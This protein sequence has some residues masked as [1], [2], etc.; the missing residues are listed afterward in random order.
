MS[1]PQFDDPDAEGAARMAQMVAMSATVIEALARLQAHRTGQRADEDERTAAA[2]RAQR[3]ADHAAA[4]V[5]WSAAH[6]DDW[7]RR[8]STA[9][10][11]R[12]WSA[13]ASWAS[14]DPDAADTL[15]RVETRLHQLHPEA[16]AAYHEARSC[17]VRPGEAMRG[18]AERFARPLALSDGADT[19]ARSAG[20]STAAR[21]PGVVAADAYPYSTRDGVAAA[22]RGQ[23][24]VITTAPDHTPK[25]TS[26]ASTRR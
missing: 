15:R 14:S 1:Q 17:G 25:S 24:H 12:A 16:M 18:A 26:R 19:P 11:G 21:P 2:S 10:L 3:T 9:D 13:A 6:D 22:A 4:R 20:S 8:A 23:V 7:L 5:A